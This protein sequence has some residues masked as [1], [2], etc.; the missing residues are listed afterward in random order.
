MNQTVSEPLGALPQKGDACVLLSFVGQRPSAVAVA[1]VTWAKH[2]GVPMRVELLVTSDVDSRAYARLS[3]LLSK[4]IPGIQLNR[5]VMADVTDAVSVVRTIAQNLNGARLVF[6]VDAGL[7]FGVAKLARDLAVLQP[8]IASATDSELLVAIP[9]GPRKP[10]SLENL[11]FEDLLKLYDIGWSC[12]I[13]PWPTELVGEPKGASKCVTNLSLRHE[14]HELRFDLAFELKGRLH[15]VILVARDKP[16]PDV[17]VV[18]R[19]EVLFAPGVLCNLQPRVLV[20]S[21][22]PGVLIE[23]MSAGI[24]GVRYSQLGEQLAIS[25]PGSEIN[26][27]D[28]SWGLFRGTAAW[29]DQPL[30]LWMSSPDPSSTLVALFAHRPRLARIIVDTSTPRVA[31]ACSRLVAL[32]RQRPDLVPC[33][34]TYIPSKDVSGTLS[35]GQVSFLAGGDSVFN[36]TPGTKAQKATLAALSSIPL[37]S[38]DQRCEQA[39]CLTSKAS[40]PLNHVPLLVQAHVVAGIQSVRGRPCEGDDVTEWGSTEVDFH[41]ALGEIVRNWLIR[42][43]QATNIDLS[44]L[45]NVP[46]PIEGLLLDSSSGRATVT[47]NGQR[48][49]GQ[50]REPRSG[51]WLEDVVAACLRKGLETC[52]RSDFEIRVGMGLAFVEETLEIGDPRRGN[53]R[54]DAD[55][56]ARVGRDFF[57]FDAKAGENPTFA[58]QRWDA[59]ACAR[60]FGRFCVPISVRP[61]IGRDTKKPF[62]APRVGAAG[63]DLG[64]LLD[65]PEFV[66]RLAQMVSKRRTF[67]PSDD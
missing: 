9:G 26:A 21:D 46:S 63:L 30:V 41:V 11:E 66:Q 40:M 65:F 33:E 32:T 18:R 36:V 5:S 44:D 13:S 51:K 24:A 49:G 45:N 1:V 22:S 20:C 53:P 17:D 54:T 37:W 58:K 6:L 34:I 48:F 59:V 8:V 55:V 23:A 39:R 7:G 56:F 4:K 25:T 19:P 60:M 3:G 28:V 31:L 42:R 64:D 61:A 62:R 57:L 50:V 27:P 15:V 35:D 2:L 16:R 52:R 43:G 29:R 38:I 14:E 67:N 12:G 10:Y 47:L